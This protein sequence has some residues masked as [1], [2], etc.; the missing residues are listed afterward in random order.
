MP[1]QVAPTHIL[2]HEANAVLSGKARVHLHKERV[3]F[4]VGDLEH[5]FLRFQT[6]VNRESE[7]ERVNQ[8]EMIDNQKR[9][10]E[11]EKKKRR[12]KTLTCQVPR[13][14]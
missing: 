2:H 12:K 8:G 10:K 3:S 7:S 9:K 13:S 14:Q 4:A 6:G 1:H 5:S 11:A